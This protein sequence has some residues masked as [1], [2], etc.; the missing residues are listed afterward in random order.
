MLKNVFLVAIG[1]GAGS[2][3]RYLTA[4]LVSKYYSQ[5]FPFATFIANVAGCLFTGLLIGFLSK[6]QIAGQ[7]L[8]WLLITGFCGGYTTFAAFG[9]ENVSLF[10]NN[11]ATLA[12]AYIAISISAGLA[13][14]WLGLFLSR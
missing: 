8:K 10:Q 6:M 7:D 3:L 5:A 1:G 11:N 14:V 2:A 13:A 4:V 9:Y 12:L